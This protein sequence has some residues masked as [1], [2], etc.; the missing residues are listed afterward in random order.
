MANHCLSVTT[1]RVNGLVLCESNNGDRSA[2][3]SAEMRRDYIR[4]EGKQQQGLP[5]V[6]RHDQTKGE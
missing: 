5:L 1:A 3:A 4:L 6:E 2:L